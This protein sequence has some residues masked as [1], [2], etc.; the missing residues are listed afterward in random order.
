[1]MKRYKVE[2]TKGGNRNWRDRAP[3]DIAVGAIGMARGMAS[4]YTRSYNYNRNRFYS[5]SWRQAHS[6]NHPA[7]HKNRH[8]N[9]SFSQGFIKKY[10]LVFNVGT[11][12]KTL[13][14]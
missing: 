9:R 12:N 5:A 7:F 3:S 11:Y 1:M 6:L 4:N 8:F 2:C 13:V 14:Q 10:E